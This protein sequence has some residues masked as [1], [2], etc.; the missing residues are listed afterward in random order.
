MSIYAANILVTPSGVFDANT[1]GAQPSTAFALASHVHSAAD[2]TSGTVPVTRGGTGRASIGVGS[3]VLGDGTNAV[4]LLGPGAALTVPL[5]QGTAA[6]PIM[7]NLVASGGVSIANVGSDLRIYAPT[8]GSITGLCTK[9]FDAPAEA[10]RGVGANR[11]EADIPSVSGMTSSSYCLAFDSA[12]TETAQRNIGTLPNDSTWLNDSVA[13]SI[14]GHAYSATS[15]S[16]SWVLAS[17]QTITGA[18]TGAFTDFATVSAAIPSNTGSAYTS[19]Y[20][21]S[22]TGL[23]W[24]AGATIEMQL[25]RLTTGSSTHAADSLFHSLTGYRRHA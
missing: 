24:S 2:I 19:S 1:A 20:V 21:S 3:I 13:M 16:I 12:T 5:G 15:G 23:G 6:N 17:R 25:R 14:V 4:A 9:L 8:G 22:V 7:A 11:P 10:W 18:W